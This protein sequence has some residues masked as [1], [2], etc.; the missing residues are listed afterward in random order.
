VPGKI[1]QDPL[2]AARAGFGV[3]VYA[4]RVRE[5]P[6]DEAGQFPRNG[7]CVVC[8]LAVKPAPAAV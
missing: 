1:V 2:L 8:R 4:H 7:P 6:Y 3:K 5:K